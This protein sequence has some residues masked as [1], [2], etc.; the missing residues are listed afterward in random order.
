MTV[1]IP[2]NVEIEGRFLW[3]REFEPLCVRALACLVARKRYGNWPPKEMPRLGGRNLLL[4]C[5]FFSQAKSSGCS[6]RCWRKDKN[7]VPIRDAD[8]RRLCVSWFSM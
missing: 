8:E 1:G 3:S 7:G 4:G 2:I 6:R 5:F